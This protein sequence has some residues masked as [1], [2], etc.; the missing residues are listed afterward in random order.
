MGIL[1]FSKA[2][3]RSK[4]KLSKISS[5]INIFCKKHPKKLSSRQHKRLRGM[6]RKRASAL[7]KCLG[8]KVSSLH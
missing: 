5:K 2:S 3:R 1:D 4:K 6:L 8:V 7:S